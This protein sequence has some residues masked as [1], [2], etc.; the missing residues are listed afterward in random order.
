MLV[1]IINTGRPAIMRETGQYLRYAMDYVK[2]ASQRSSSIIWTKNCWPSHSEMQ[3]SHDLTNVLL[4][5]RRRNRIVRR[6][7]RSLPIELAFGGAI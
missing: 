5:L 1:R 7:A 4:S 2:T 6:A 3:G